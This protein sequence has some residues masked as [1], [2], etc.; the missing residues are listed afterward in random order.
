MVGL[1]GRICGRMVRGVGVR[2]R[3][4]GGTCICWRV[5]TS[6]FRCISLRYPV[7][8]H[9]PLLPHRFPQ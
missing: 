1:K 6:W 2:L 4:G 8:A 7:V 3:T 9:S 5:V